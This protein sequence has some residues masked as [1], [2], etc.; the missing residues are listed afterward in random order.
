MTAATSTELAPASSSI[1]GDYDG[2]D[3]HA[4]KLNYNDADNDDSTKRKDRDNDSDNAGNSYYDSDDATVRGYGRA[5]NG[6]DR[7]TIAALVSRYFAAAAREDG[8]TACSMIVK[9]YANSVP[10]DLGRPP[11]PPYSRGGTCA[12]VLSKLFYHY[13][14]QLA[15]HA[16]Q[17]EVTSVRTGQGRAVAV[18]GFKT[19]PGRALWVAREGSVWKVDALLDL[20]LP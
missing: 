3:D 1:T 7:R 16:A 2:D 4:N 14:R 13:H 11:G 8:A 10:E 6:R 9:V 5:A 20:E 19:L 17:L 15:A 18:L 12:A